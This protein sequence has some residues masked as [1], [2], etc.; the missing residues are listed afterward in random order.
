MTDAFVP[1]LPVVRPGARAWFMTA[2][3]ET[4]MVA[5]D[6][7]G[8]VVPVFLPALIL[9][10]TGN[11]TGLDTPLPDAD[12][13]TAFDVH[14]LPLTVA[15]VVAMVAIVN[16]P[17]FLA[18]YRHTGVLRRLGAT[19]ASP[20]M[21]L[22]AQ[23]AV[24]VAQILVGLA[25]TL[26]VARVG[27]GAHVPVDGWIAAGV[28]ALSVAACLALGLLVAAVAPTPQ[29]AVAIGLVVFLGTAAVGGL[30]G[31]LANLPEPVATVGTLLPFGATVEAL[32]AAWGGYPVPTS[33]VV[34]LAVTTGAGGLLAAAR[35]RW[36]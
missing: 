23:A 15:F 21:V 6:T 20:M 32:G 8:L 33:A 14:L 5:R 3:A 13:R 4:R 18:A 27:F 17:S 22:V 30:F 9:V 29:S 34:G 12:G 24:S 35:F 28:L 11:Q 1:D 7:A 25:V 2:L 10:M 16:M 26:G 19:P 36:E 31:G